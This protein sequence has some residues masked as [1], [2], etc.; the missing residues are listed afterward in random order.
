[1]ASFEKAARGGRPFGAFPYGIPLLWRPRRNSN[2]ER[3]S[4]AFCAVFVFVVVVVG[5]GKGCWRSWLAGKNEC[6]GIRTTTTTGKGTPDFPLTWRVVVPVRP[7]P[8]GL[9][10]KRAR[11]SGPVVV[12]VVVVAAVAAG[13][14]L[15]GH[16]RN[17]SAYANDAVGTRGGVKGSAKAKP[18]A[19]RWRQMAPIYRESRGRHAKP[20]QEGPKGERTNGQSVS[21]PQS[22]SLRDFIG[23]SILRRAIQKA[24]PHTRAEGKDGGRLRPDSRLTDVAAPD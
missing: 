10:E 23:A 22:Q 13:G 5:S 14:L 19:V 1:M 16:A 9:N 21:Q 7:P 6:A 2:I 24:R 11:D 3:A 4:A 20:S 12:V 17:R 8:P 18:A 15:G